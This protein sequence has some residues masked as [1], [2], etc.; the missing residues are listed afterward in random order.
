[1]CLFEIVTQYKAIFVEEARPPPC[2]AG[3][4]A[5]QSPSP[6]RARA[7]GRGRTRATRFSSSGCTGGFGRC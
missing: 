5:S 7:L 2:A 6:Q 1:V 4:A 3:I